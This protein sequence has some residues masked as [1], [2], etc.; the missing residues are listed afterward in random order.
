MPKKP[1]KKGS[2][3]LRAHPRHPENADEPS[4]TIYWNRVYEK[5][6]TDKLRLREHGLPPDTPV[7]RIIQCDREKATLYG[8]VDHIGRKSGDLTQVVRDIIEGRLPE[9]Y[10][11]TS[12]ILTEPSP[13]FLRTR[14]KL[15]RVE[16]RQQKGR[17][18]A[19]SIGDKMTIIDANAQPSDEAI[20]AVAH[21]LLDLVRRKDEEAREA[22]HPR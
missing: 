3:S 11:P 22:G 4:L 19:E 13:F 1:Q 14:G 10:T 5:T 7:F 21:L 8:D 18:T 6:R 15:K 20:E 16:P 2:S 9:D 17:M 12:P